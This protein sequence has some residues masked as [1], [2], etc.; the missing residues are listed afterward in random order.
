MFYAC[1]VGKPRLSLLTAVFIM[2][3]REILAPKFEHGEDAS[4]INQVSIPYVL[5][6]RGWK[7]PPIVIDGGIHYG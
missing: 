1:G 6:M 2:Y 3:S 4:I 7:T 5:S